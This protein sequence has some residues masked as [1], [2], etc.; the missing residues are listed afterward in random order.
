MSAVERLPGHG[1]GPGRLQESTERLTSAAANGPA[2]L[3]A[4]Q[5][6]HYLLHSPDMDRLATAAPERSAPWRALPIAVLDHLLL[7]L[8]GIGGDRVELVHDDSAAAV[9]AARSG[10]DTAVIAPPLRVE[11]VYAVAARGELTPRK[12]TSFGPKPRTGLV[13]RSLD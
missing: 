10:L 3:L 12:S 4:A 8:W 1:A 11:D 6:D 5:G 13:L 7:P 2:L 9:A